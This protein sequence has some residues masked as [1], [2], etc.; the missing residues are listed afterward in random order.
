LLFVEE[1]HLSID[2]LMCLVVI[3]GVLSVWVKEHWGRGGSL[4]LNKIHYLIIIWEW[5]R[6]GEGR[7]GVQGSFS[8]RK[9]KNK[10]IQ[11]WN[12]YPLLLWKVSH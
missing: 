2:R 9:E 10:K 11:E 12:P 4:H 7:S 5:G 1:V 8:F 6:E 3:I